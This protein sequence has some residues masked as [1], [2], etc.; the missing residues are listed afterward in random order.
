[1]EAD[2]AGLAL[3]ATCLAHRADEEGVVRGHGHG[4]V[5]VF[6]RLVEHLDLVVDE[7]VS[8]LLHGHLGGA[9]F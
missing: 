2:G 5:E 7:P 4:R 3:Q 8:A 9:Q 1:V 6:V